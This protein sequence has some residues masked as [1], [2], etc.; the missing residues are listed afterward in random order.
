LFQEEA[1][2]SEEVLN[3]KVAVVVFIK[4]V[5]T[6]PGKNLSLSLCVCVCVCVEGGRDYLL[7]FILFTFQK[8]WNFAYHFC[9]FV[10]YLTLL[11]L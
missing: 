3:G 7:T 10:D 4:A 6:L 2:I 5:D 9:Q 8:K 11:K 1:D